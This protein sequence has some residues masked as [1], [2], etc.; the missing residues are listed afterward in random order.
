MKASI[1]TSVR[2]EALFV[3][4]LQ[5]SDC[6]SSRQVRSEVLQCVGRLGAAGCAALVAQEYGEHPVEATVRMRWAT[7]MVRAAYPAV[8]RWTLWP[9]NRDPAARRSRPASRAGA[10]P[11]KD[12]PPTP[13]ASA[14]RAHA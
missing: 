10:T 13:E 11:P 2:A 7:A 1:I 6:P 9:S 12:R 4:Y 5:P 8:E 3:S 14:R